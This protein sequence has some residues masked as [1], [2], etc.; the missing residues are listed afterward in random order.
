MGIPLSVVWL[1][2]VGP[3]G[4]TARMTTEQAVRAG[5]CAYGSASARLYAGKARTEV[6]GLPGQA[7]GGELRSCLRE[8]VLCCSTAMVACWLVRS[9]S[10]RMATGETILSGRLGSS[11]GI[12]DWVVTCREPLSA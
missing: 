9:A 8:I 5:G 10:A 2:A 11:D 4:M 12:H 1:A 3:G 6:S 7:A